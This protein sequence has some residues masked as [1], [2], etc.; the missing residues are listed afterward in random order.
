MRELETED[1]ESEALLNVKVHLWM[2]EV[3][4]PRDYSRSQK[5]LALTVLRQSG[6]C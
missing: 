2:P 1:K 6:V 3:P 5:A 4:K